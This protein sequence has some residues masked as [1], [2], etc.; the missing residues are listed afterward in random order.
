M[1]SYS[2]TGISHALTGGAPRAS[3]PQDIINS[4]GGVIPF[5]EFPSS[6]R[7]LPAVKKLTGST[8]SLFGE[9]WSAT[10]QS[11]LGRTKE[12]GN[13]LKTAEVSEF[14]KTGLGI[15]MEQVAKLVKAHS[16]LETNRDVFHVQLGG[17]DTHKNLEASLTL[18]MGEIDDALDAFKNEMVAQG[19]WDDV[20]VVTAS[21][22]GRTLTSNGAGTDHA[23]GGNYWMMGGEVKGARIHGDYPDD[24]TSNGPLNIG[25]GRL[26]PTT[27]WE[28][29]WNGIVAWFGVDTN[30]GI[31]KVLPNIGKFPVET[32]LTQEELFV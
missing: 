12:L 3:P 2:V 14:P 19:L 4:A 24:L 31:E 10:V 9:T 22:F 16:D 5:D 21:D 1:G 6:A 25:R 28:G 11:M 20:V 8:T 27:S 7:I 26:I 17:F 18:K 30:G 29:V 15:Q 13:A 32:L 23:W